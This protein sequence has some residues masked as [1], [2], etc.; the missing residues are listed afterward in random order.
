MIKVERIPNGTVYRC[1]ACGFTGNAREIKS[2]GIELNPSQKD[3]RR[4]QY[5]NLCVGCAE[6]LQREL[7]RATGYYPKENEGKK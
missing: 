5:F 3:A 7:A 4:D 2:Y 1:H 6:A